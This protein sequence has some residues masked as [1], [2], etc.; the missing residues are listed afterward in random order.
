MPR[1]H[2]Q[3]RVEIM[4]H[5]GAAAAPAAKR[6]SGMVLALWAGLAAAALSGCAIGGGKAVAGLD[7]IMTA[8]ISNNAAAPAVDGEI[9]ADSPIVLA[10]L[11]SLNGAAG[12]DWR[13]SDSGSRGTLSAYAAEPRRGRLCRRFETTRQSYDGISLY[14]GEACKAQAGPWQLIYLNEK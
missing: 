12:G 1:R 10:R 14:Q 8:S 13:N 7:N 3:Q 2:Y 4:E 5:L 9:A 11:S 6:R